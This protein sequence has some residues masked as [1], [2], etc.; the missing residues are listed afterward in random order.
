M[1]NPIRNN[2][3]LFS[4]GTIVGLVLLLGLAGWPPTAEAASK[5]EIDWPGLQVVRPG[6][7]TTV[8]L[9]QDQ[10]PRGSWEIKGLF[11]SATED[12]LTLTLQH[13]PLRTFPKA[14]IRQVL[15]DSKRIWSRVQAVKPRTRTTVVLYQDQAPRGSRKI[16]GLFH[17]AT[18]DSLTLERQDGQR[19]TFQK[20]AVRK[21][22]VHRPPGKRYQRWITAAV[23]TA[24][25]IPIMTTFVAS[26]DLDA[27]GIFATV[28]FCIALPT[29]L[30][31]LVAPKMGGIYNVPPKH[32]MQPPADQPSGD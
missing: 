6:T 32:R 15:V 4:R 2:V 28:G 7:R 5:V 24:I 29:A 11:R 16:K 22:L 9:Y 14:A 3:R 20:L 18:D 10:A 13:G 21:V 17:S 30:T 23:S 31:F 26:G 1:R 19:H 12:S 27:S 25:M 8:V